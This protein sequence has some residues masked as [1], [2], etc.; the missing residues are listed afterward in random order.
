MERQALIGLIDACVTEFDSDGLAD[1]V[2]QLHAELPVLMKSSSEEDFKV[3]VQAARLIA[4]VAQLEAWCPGGQRRTYFSYR[5]GEP[6]IR[7]DPSR[8]GFEEISGPQG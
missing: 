2:T 7:P 8:E 1:L 3:M 4:R 5:S 6:F